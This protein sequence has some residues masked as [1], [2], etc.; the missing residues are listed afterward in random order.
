MSEN[1]EFRRPSDER[2]RLLACATFVYSLSPFQLVNKAFKS[3]RAVVTK[4][5]LHGGGRPQIGE[6]TPHLSCK[7]DQIKIGDYMD[8]RVTPPKWVASPTWGPTPPCKQ[9]LKRRSLC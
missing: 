3:A 4:A 5:C 8:R 9:A 1:T 6:V 7:R 2:L